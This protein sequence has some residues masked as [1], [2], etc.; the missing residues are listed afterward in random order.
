MK[1]VIQNSIIGLAISAGL[2]SQAFAYTQLTAQ[3]D[4]GDRGVNVTNLQTYLADLPSFYPS[5]LV[6][7]YFGGL[8]KAGVMRFQ[9]TY[10]FDQVGRVGPVTLAKI[11]ELMG[12]N[13]VSGDI[14]GPAFYNVSM[15]K[16]NNSAT[17]TFNTNEGTTARVVY[18]TNALAFNEGDIDSVG[19]GAVGS[20]DTVS[21]NGMS[22]AHSLT[23]SNLYSNTDYY[24]TIIATDA[25]G[26]VSV[27][28]PNNKFR[29]Q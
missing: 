12:G 18:R 17:L 11:N 26:N 27:V 23:M 22:S 5:G 9:A 4:P 28:G 7:G 8:T 3:L 20:F 2:V 24:Y 19:F 1:K 25:K 6:T 16:S 13:T 14:S 21:S 29:T 15:S 10:G